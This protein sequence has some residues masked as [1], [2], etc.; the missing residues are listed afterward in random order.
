MSSNHQTLPKSQH[1]EEL[2]YSQTDSGSVDIRR[3][4]YDLLEN[5]KDPEYRDGFIEA[6]VYTG[7]AFQIRTLREKQDMTQIALGKAARMAQERISILEDPNAETKPTINTLLRLAKAFH[8]GLQVR[9]APFSKLIDQAVRTDED[10]LNVPTFEQ[11]VAGIERDLSGKANDVDD[12]VYWEPTPGTLPA[13]S[14]VALLKENGVPA[15]PRKPPA[16]TDDLNRFQD[17]AAYSSNTI[18]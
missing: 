9:F 4:K 5:L 18:I 15:L 16:R 2:L 13:D 3:A 10:D 6:H 11:E 14:A 1:Q 17:N 12:G 8:V 7:I